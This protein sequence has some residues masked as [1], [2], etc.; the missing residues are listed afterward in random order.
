[1]PQLPIKV[2]LFQLFL[3][4][5]LMK[6]FRV[7]KHFPSRTRPDVKGEEVDIV[8]MRLAYDDRINRMIPAPSGVVKVSDPEEEEDQRGRVVEVQLK[9]NIT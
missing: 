7:G 9:W 8:E 5:I 3:Q 4:I 6:P 1:M 2:T